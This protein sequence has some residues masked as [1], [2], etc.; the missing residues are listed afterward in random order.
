MKN[1][2]R[3]CVPITLCV[4]LSLALVSPAFAITPHENPLEAVPSYSGL[5]I[6]NYY[7]ETLDYVIG[8]LPEE[9][10]MMM[11]KFQFANIPEKLQ[12]SANE[13]SI[14]SH[15]VATA[16][17]EIKG[18]LDT[19]D[20]LI[21]QYRFEEAKTLMAVI[22]DA[23][24][25]TEESLNSIE[26]AVK[27]AGLV[28]RVFSVDDANSLKIS[29]NEALDKVLRLRAILNH[30]L[31]LYNSFV[32]FDTGTLKETTLTLEVASGD[33]Y[34]GDSISVAGKLT[35]AGYNMPGRE[36]EI[37]INGA[38]AYTFRTDGAGRFNGVIEIPLWYVREIH[39]QAVFY[40][41]GGDI[42][43]YK[44]ALSPLV[45][46][47]V[48]YYVTGL[49][50]SLDKVAY[51]GRD[52]TIVGD[53]NYTDTP[54]PGNRDIEVYLDNTLISETT[55]SNHFVMAVFVPPDFE[56]GKH[57][58]T[59]SVK[60]LGRYNPFLQDYLLDVQ[61]AVP[62]IVNNYPPV[63]F[64]PGNTVI[65]GD[66]KSVVGPANQC[67]VKARFLGNTFQTVTSETG[68]FTLE[69][70]KN[71][72]LGLFG[73]E[74]IDI[75]VLPSESWHSVTTVKHSIMV[76]YPL[77]CGILLVAIVVVNILGSRRLRPYFRSRRYQRTN[78]EV[79]TDISMV[80][81]VPAMKNDDQKQT[82]ELP[83]EAKGASGILLSL[84]KL[85]IQLVQK[86]SGILPQPHQTLREY[87]ASE[88]TTHNV[89]YKYALEL[90]RLVEKV[91][92]SNRPL[93]EEESKLG[94]TLVQK[95]KET[96]P[97]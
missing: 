40:P 22:A 58:L 87:L 13:F 86:I 66:V 15:L 96:E 31:A 95:I 5:Y 47:S 23:I 36:I 82:V 91:I 69:M 54:A 51:P 73:L 60:S 35:S 97:K 70:P 39:V 77:N 85:V 42:G 88:E 68:A 71:W 72:G 8:N 43:I 50:L 18:N 89:F 29:Y 24:V 17:P 27:D 76:I 48:H 38:S 3:F 25:L 10:D 65:S 83:P 78:P 46:L 53:F 59:V 55:V 52:T 20:E 30:Y 1:I 19:L 80:A 75:S 37:L 94:V 12:D 49:T 14:S 16:L 34:V 61:K 64:I 62:I 26:S 2:F 41:R 21:S 32:I 7:S 90:T 57:L 9:V 79:T 84:Y 93:T 92:Y 6:L 11:D 45:K 28:F 56:L 67:I 33:V 63:A 81:T 74:K 44:S 4:A